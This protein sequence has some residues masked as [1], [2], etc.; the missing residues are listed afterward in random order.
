MKQIHVFVIYQYIK[1]V[2]SSTFMTSTL[3]SSAW[4][5]KTSTYS[6]VGFYPCCQWTNV[7]VQ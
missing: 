5:K 4:I 3:I 6:S 7:H 1:Q 2:K